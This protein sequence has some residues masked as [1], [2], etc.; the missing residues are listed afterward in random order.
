MISYI[1]KIK[2]EHPLYYMPLIFMVF[3]FT[4]PFYFQYPLWTLLPSSL[5]LVSYLY[6][7][8]ARVT[9]LTNV[10]WTYLLAYIVFMT[11][12]VNGGMMWFFFY[13]VNLLVYRFE[14]T[15]RSYRYLSFLFAN[16]LITLLT[17]IWGADFGSRIMA[18]LLP[19][20]NFTLVFYWT[21]ERERDK[22]EKVIFQQHQTINLLAAENERNRIGRDLHDSL[23]H[24]FAMMT[25]KTE[26]ALKQLEKENLTAVQ[27]ELQEINH[28][29]RQSMQEVRSIV[30]NLKYRSFSEELRI[31]EDMFSQ[32]AI[33]LT[34]DNHLDSQTLSPVLQ[35]SLVM[36]VRELTNNIIKHSQAKSA[37]LTVWRDKGVHVSMTDDGCGFK[38]LTGQEL[39]SIKERL[40]LVKGEVSV[41]S[42]KNPTPIEV[43]LS[44]G[45]RE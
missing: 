41:T 30:S 10:V 3:P 21:R 18:I 33:D 32:S 20:I 1:K 44:E 25:L 27:K 15:I 4:G 42:L 29:S 22:Q 12:A 6:I 38:D 35:S 5:F 34:I 24:T 17:L 8:H 36:I 28:I 37:R 7:I 14:D 2:W 19:L 11:L 40:Q 16:F 31:L 13:T 43:V 26:L 9:W 39:Y 45:V 23:G